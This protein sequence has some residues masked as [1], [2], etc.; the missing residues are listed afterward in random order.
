MDTCAAP[1]RPDLRRRDEPDEILS[2]LTLGIKDYFQ[3]LGFSKAVLGLSGG[4]DSAVVAVLAARALG[5]ENVTGVLMPSVY[6]AG[7]SVD[8]A[9]ILAANLGI[10][11]KLIPIKN[12]YAG[13]LKGTQA[14]PTAGPCRKVRADRGSAPLNNSF[15][16]PRPFEAPGE[17]TGAKEDGEVSLTM[18][19]LQARIRGTILMALANSNNWLALTTGNKSEIALGYC[20]LYGDTAGAIAPIADLLKTEVYRL[21]AVINRDSEII[22]RAIIKGADRRT[23]TRQKDQDL[24]PYAVL[25]AVIRSIWRRT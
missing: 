17:I 1:P 6:T 8:D 24:P 5:P 9:L 25:D 14:A 20:T 18:Q 23:Q 22:P 19:N 4:I 11:T 10:R 3:K 21:A 12:I 7:R 16:G 15:A 13:L 2:A